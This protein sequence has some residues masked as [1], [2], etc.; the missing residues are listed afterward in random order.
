MGWIL[1]D[2]PTKHGFPIIATKGTHWTLDN[3]RFVLFAPALPIPHQLPYRHQ[4]LS[5]FATVL[6]STLYRRTAE[7]IIAEPSGQVGLLSRL[8]HLK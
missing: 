5:G 2:F 7:N 3:A 4:L 1:I 8:H 6:A